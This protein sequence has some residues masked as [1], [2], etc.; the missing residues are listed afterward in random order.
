MLDS[1]NGEHESMAIFSNAF[2]TI[3]KQS[4]KKPNIHFKLRIKKEKLSQSLQSFHFNVVNK[5]QK[6]FHDAKNQL[7]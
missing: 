7:S 5:T 4:L 6:P 2:N 3:L 1:L